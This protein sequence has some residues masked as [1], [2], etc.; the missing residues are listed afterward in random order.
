MSLPIIT[1]PSKTCKHA[2]QPCMYFKVIGNDT[3]SRFFICHIHSYRS[4]TC[5]EVDPDALL[6]CAKGE[7]DIIYI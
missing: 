7:K 5:S 1:V 4:T 2:E 6:D 3:D